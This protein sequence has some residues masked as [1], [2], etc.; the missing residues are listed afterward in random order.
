VYIE[1]KMPD[2]GLDEVEVTEILVKIDEEVKLD[3]AL[4]T[5]E[6]DKASMEIPSQISGIVKKILVKIGDKVATSSLI[7]IFKVDDDKF[8]N[9]KKSNHIE[10]EKKS[11]ESI[12][13]NKK[14]FL[15]M[16]HQ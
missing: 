2:I 10:I 14:N 4:I 6:G 11:D 12:L 7:M 3:Q 9:K 16:Q 5:V 1:V 13:E 15:F 8:Q